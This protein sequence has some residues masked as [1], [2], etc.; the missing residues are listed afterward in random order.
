[1]QVHH[2][3]AFDENGYPALYVF[4]TCREFIRTFPALIYDRNAPE[5]IDTNCEDHDY[6]AMRY[7]LMRNPIPAR[8]IPEKKF[9]G[10]N[11]YYK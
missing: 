7:F 9:E 3:L 2:R 8:S 6:D 4:D 5:D 11:V 1:M 10:V